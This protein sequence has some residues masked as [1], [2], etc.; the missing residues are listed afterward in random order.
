[1]PGKIF[2]FAAASAA[3]TFSGMAQA[4]SITGYGSAVFTTLRACG[5]PGTFCDGTQA[6]ISQSNLTGGAGIEANTTFSGAGI[7]AG[8]SAY[9]ALHFAGVGLPQVRASAN[10][11]GDVRV[12]TNVYFYQTYTYTGADPIDFGLAGNIHV[13]D[14]STDGSSDPDHAGTFENGGIVYAGLTIWSAPSFFSFSDAGSFMGDY[15]WQFSARCGD[16]AGV[17][18]A[19]N[20]GTA[21]PGGEQSYGFATS[22]CSGGGPL[23]L[24][25]GDQ[26]VVAGIMQ[27]PVNRGGWI[28]ATNTF[29]V[30]LDPSLGAETIHALTSSLAYTAAP[31]PATWASMMLGFGAI[32]VATRRRKAALAA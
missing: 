14:S 16:D 24:H 17:L 7:G 22:N 19:G 31:E 12:N 20:Y 21:L 2:L 27:F 4:Q 15:N 6:P 23:T 10:A 29:T 18:A 3:L 28:D 1:M 9:G 5:A 11:V 8:S 26:F 32:G 30:S 25:S 13:V